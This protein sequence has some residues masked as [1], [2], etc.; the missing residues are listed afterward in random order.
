MYEEV[1]IRSEVYQTRYPELKDSLN[2]NINVN[3]VNNNLLVGCTN[4]ILY[5]YPKDEKD[6]IQSI[7]KEN[8]NLES[9]DKELAYYLQDSVLSSHGLKPI[10]FSEIG[11]KGN[12]YQERANH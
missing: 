11:P 7:L 9:A 12:I 6:H 2:A 5:R 1:D 8:I 4:D 3:Y 10:P